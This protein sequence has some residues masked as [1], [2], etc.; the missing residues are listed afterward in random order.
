M[1][2]K[3]KSK[4]NQG[5]YGVA[6][7]FT[8]DTGVSAVKEKGNFKGLGY[9][10]E[11]IEPPEETNKVTGDPS[12]DKSDRTVRPLV[13]APF[14]KGQVDKYKRV[15]PETYTGLKFKQT[16]KDQ[17]L[18]FLGEPTNQTLKQ[19]Q[20][21]VKRT[22]RFS[23]LSETAEMAKARVKNSV[24]NKLKKISRTTVEYNPETKISEI[25]SGTNKLF[26][27]PKNIT[28]IQKSLEYFNIK[29]PMIRAVI[30]SGFLINAPNDFDNFIFNEKTGEYDLGKNR[31]VG[32]L[33]ENDPNQVKAIHNF[34]TQATGAKTVE[35]LD[36]DNP[37]SSWFWCS[38]FIHDILTKVNAKPLKTSN[39]YDRIRARKYIDYGTKIADLKKDGSIDLSKIK[40]GD[41]LIIGNPNT[42]LKE[43]SEAVGAIT[44]LTIFVGDDIEGAFNA[45]LS[46][47]SDNMLLGLGGNQSSSKSLA[48]VNVK[49]FSVNQIIGVRR[50]DKVTPKMI[51]QLKH[52]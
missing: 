32:N 51:D 34:Y 28:N 14:K 46:K 9:K 52:L 48:E 18:G 10:G 15:D 13:S 8:P 22:K 41:I 27:D 29:A 3:S 33:D 37:E 16:D 47:Y 6:G 7:K 21:E 50:I 31:F 39:S 25:V 36:I 26:Q 44:H 19:R 42:F 23:G 40:S 49:P 45:S 2:T 11:I 35:E 20:E 5:G 38:A 43:G 4:F 12:K 17:P 24:F 1:P 30:E